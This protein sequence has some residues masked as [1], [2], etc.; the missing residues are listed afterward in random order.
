[1]ARDKIRAG[2]H[3]KAKV[4]RHPEKVFKKKEYSKKQFG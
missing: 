2:G 4:T 3:R 1:M